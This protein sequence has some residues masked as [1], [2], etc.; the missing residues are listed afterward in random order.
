MRLERERL[1]KEKEERLRTWNI[2]SEKPNPTQSDPRIINKSD[3]RTFNQSDPKIINQSDAKVY[4]AMTPKLKEMSDYKYT[5]AT[6]NESS[7][8]VPFPLND[9]SKPLHVETDRQ[10]YSSG[11][12]DSTSP[13]K[14]QPVKS[15]E[16]GYSTADYNSIYPRE[17][18]PP[19]KLENENSLNSKPLYEG[20]AKTADIYA[21]RSPAKELINQQKS[22]PAIAKK[23]L[24]LRKD[25][26]QRSANYENVVYR[27]NDVNRGRENRSSLGEEEFRRYSYAD[28]AREEAMRV[29]RRPKSAYEDPVIILC[30][31]Y[32]FCTTH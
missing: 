6:Q 22:G 4:N 2:Q 15:A 28:A 24:L 13:Y 12:I 3:P 20:R 25:Q 27:S 23:P 30:F 31:M 16:S 10:T 29:S 19:E 14:Q 9:Y 8:N 7:S 1:Q 5:I 21:P 32:Q 18:S 11:K 26:G 17:H